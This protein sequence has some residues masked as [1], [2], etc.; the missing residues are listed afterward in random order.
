MISIGEIEFSI[1]NVFA[2][3]FHFEFSSASMMCLHPTSTTR[4]NI[5]L[6]T[7]TNLLSRLPIDAN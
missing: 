4:V 3:V 2:E 7:T 5:L 1:C 6:H